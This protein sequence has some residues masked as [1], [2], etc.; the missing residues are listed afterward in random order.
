MSPHTKARL[1]AYLPARRIFNISFKGAFLALLI[2]LVL[3]VLRLCGVEA[4]QSSELGQQVFPAL[5]FVT[6]AAYAIRA[7][8]LRA[9]WSAV[10]ARELGIL[11]SYLTDR[12]KV[13]AAAEDDE[14]NAPF[15]GKLPVAIQ[16]GLLE[17]ARQQGFVSWKDV[18]RVFA[19]A[20]HQGRPF[21]TL[22]VGAHAEPAAP[23]DAWLALSS[24]AAQLDFATPQG[25]AIA[26]PR[27]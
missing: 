3:S 4:A 10:S 2:C 23:L 25:A 1:V 12:A 13:H 18:Q 20:G 22:F 11:G 26:R 5:S 9:G 21:E 7:T 19:S 8:L 15:L 24:P 27:M 6:I 16:V 14:T 17:V